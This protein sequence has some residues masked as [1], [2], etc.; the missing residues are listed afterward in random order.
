MKKSAIF[1]F[2]AG[3][4]LVCAN[5]P[6]LILGQ[7]N[8]VKGL[9]LFTVYLSYSRLAAIIAGAFNLRV[10]QL[11]IVGNDQNFANQFRLAL[12]IYLTCAVGL[13]LAAPMAIT[14]LYG[15][16]FVAELGSARIL[17]GSAVCFHLAEMLNERFKGRSTVTPDIT[18][19]ATY[20]VGTMAAAVLMVP[21]H[22]LLGLAI[23]VVVGDVARLATLVWLAQRIGG[24][25]VGSLF[26]IRTTDFHELKGRLTRTFARVKR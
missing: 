22:G 13:Y 18:S 21:S 24:L 11:S 8:E 20:A 25:R 3:F 4:A 17:L 16:D 10:F 5:V 14:L 15:R 19:Q 23:A 1:V 6:Q 12:L 9:G 2:P 7:L 26:Q